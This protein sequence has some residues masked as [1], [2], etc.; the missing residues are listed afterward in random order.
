[1]ITNSTITRYAPLARSSSPIPRHVRPRKVSPR[2]RRADRELSI[3][4][5]Q[6]IVER[7]DICQVQISPHCR[8]RAE[9]THHLKKRSALGKHD[10]ENLLLSCDPCN[11]FV[12]DYPKTA[13]AAGLVIKSWEVSGLPSLPGRTEQTPAGAEGSAPVFSEGGTA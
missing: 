2:K 1:M 4:R 10:R 9:G 12:E 5:R 7:G 8:H 11:S 13:R 3:L 6:L